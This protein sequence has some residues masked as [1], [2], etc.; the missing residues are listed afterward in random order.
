MERPGATAEAAAV[1]V[2]LPEEPAWRPLRRAQGVR[3]RAARATLVDGALPRSDAA[4]RFWSRR[5]WSELAA[6]PAVSQVVL[7]L[8]REG[9]GLESL[10][11]FAAI[12]A[13]EV[14]HAALSR[15][16]ADRLGGYDEDVPAGLDVAPRSLGAPTDVPV[17]VWALANG[18][19]SE[20]VSLALIRARHA[21]TQHPIV[22]AAL[23]ETLKDEALHV[24][25][26]WH[27]ADE[28]L[29]GLSRARRAELG[30][31][32]GDLAEML[33][34]TF[35]TQGLPRATQRRERALRDETAAAGLGALPAAQED[36]VVE[37][38][39]AGI[40]ARLRRLGVPAPRRRVSGR[41]T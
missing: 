31:Y 19:F 26:A 27:V 33:R 24:R 15:A 23:T 28:V 34:R 38:A 7:A 29:P 11:A 32:A 36:A 37:E 17:A 25:V 2:H 41:R 1:K 39:L 30:D 4:R 9:A 14:R 6:V 35:G 3:A 18:C 40:T 21:A 13:D 12:A 10:G 8:T 20:T 16:L 5:T 22:R